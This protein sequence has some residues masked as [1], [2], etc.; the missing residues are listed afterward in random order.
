MAKRPET[1]T[2]SRRAPRRRRTQEEE[3]QRWK[4]ALVRDFVAQRGW[5]ALKVGTQVAGVDLERWVIHRRSEF[6]RGVLSDEMRETLEAIP[7]WSWTPIT[8]R[9]LRTVSTIEEF[10][11]RGAPAGLTVQRLYE[12][13]RW[14]VRRK[15]EIRTGLASAEVA[16][17]LES[18]PGWTWRR[19]QK[20]AF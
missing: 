3:A 5:D 17:E 16:A 6:R 8:D 20:R 13:G 7:G 18:I 19:N 2:R 15:R 1:A 12:L 4:A 9:R 11:R 10:L 14:V